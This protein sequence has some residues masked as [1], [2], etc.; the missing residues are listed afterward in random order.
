MFG[1]S[2]TKLLVLAVIIGAV[3]LL[4]RFIGQR[5]AVPPAARRSVKSEP[6]AFD[7]EYDAESDTFVVRKDKNQDK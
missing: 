3:L 5:T 4:F 6:K 7:T 2:L 1:F